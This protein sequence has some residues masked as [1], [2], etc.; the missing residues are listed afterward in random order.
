MSK[1]LLAR[2][3]AIAQQQNCIAMR[4]QALASAGLEYSAIE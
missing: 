2:V 1:L 3:A 4:W